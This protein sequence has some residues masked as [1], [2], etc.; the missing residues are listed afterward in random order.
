MNGFILIF[1]LILFAWFGA[2]VLIKI[3]DN[4][5]P[6]CGSAAAVA[7]IFLCVMIGIAVAIAGI[8]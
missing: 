7:F 6:A 3:T 4:F 8:L 1:V 5:G 2:I